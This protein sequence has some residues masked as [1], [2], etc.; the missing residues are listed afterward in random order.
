LNSQKANDKQKFVQRANTFLRARLSREGMLGLHFT[1]GV[2][3]LTLATWIFADLAEDVGNG[4]PLTITDAR[5]SNWLHAHLTPWLTTVMLVVTNVHSTVGI[6]VMA[7]LVSIYMWRKKLRGEIL[8]FVVTVYGGMLLNLWLKNIFARARPHFN[9]PLMVLTSYSFPSGHTMAATVFY[10]A[11]TAIVFSQT[12]K[13]SWRALTLAGAILMICAV[14]FSR[15][16][17]GV[18]YLSDVLGAMVEGGAWLTLCLTA[19]DLTRKSKTKKG[20]SNQS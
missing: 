17:L 20:L 19:M 7:L 12:R 8:F 4:E 13:W 6:T 16:Y 15:I 5:F 9:D 3:L 14:G 10:G 18:H 11:L 1:L 2:L